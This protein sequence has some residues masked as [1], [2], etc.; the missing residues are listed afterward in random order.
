MTER[1]NSTAR[2]RRQG[3]AG[4][5]RHFHGRWSSMTLAMGAVVNLVG[6]AGLGKLVLGA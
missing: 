5:H 2:P 6:L 1:Q 3:L 4:V